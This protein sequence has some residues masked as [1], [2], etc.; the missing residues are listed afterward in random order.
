MFNKFLPFEPV[1][2]PP[3]SRTTAR[4][5]KLRNALLEHVTPEDLSVAREKL[6]DRLVKLNVGF[7]LWKAPPTLPD[8]RWKDVD[9]LLK[10]LLDVLGS[11][12]Q[13]LKLVEDDTYICEIHAS[14]ILVDEEEQRAI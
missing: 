8:T 10:I 6:R 7:H 1:T 14:K 5:I 2:K 11:G 4:K 13:G 3:G 9:N 12:Q